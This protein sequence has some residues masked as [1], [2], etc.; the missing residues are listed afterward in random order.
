MEENIYQLNPVEAY[1]TQ[2]GLYIMEVRSKALSIVV[3]KGSKYSG[4]SNQSSA[5]S[6]SSQNQLVVS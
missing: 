1:P 2:I 3:S 6:T 4:G 5:S